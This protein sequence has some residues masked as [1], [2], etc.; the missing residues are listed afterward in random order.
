MEAI[1]LETSEARFDDFET[2]QRLHDLS[3]N[4]DS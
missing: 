1:L 3:I 2:H 4:L